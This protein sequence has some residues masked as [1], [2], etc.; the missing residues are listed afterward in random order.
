LRQT[1]TG[2]RA[3]RERSTAGHV[4]GGDQHV[5]RVPAGLVDAAGDDLLDEVAR[6]PWQAKQ[7]RN[8]VI[9]T[10]LLTHHARIAAGRRRRQ[11]DTISMSNFALLPSM[12]VTVTL[13]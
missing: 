3:G 10:W 6:R 5:Q 7:P 8:R 1:G 2:D 4:P 9:A 11:C 12:A 13:T